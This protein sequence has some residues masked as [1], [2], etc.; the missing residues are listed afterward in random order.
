[1][2]GTRLR[3]ASPGLQGLVRRIFNEGGQGRASLIRCEPDEAG[4]VFSA[5][6]HL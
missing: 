6:V 5:A 3:Q 2:P 1:M 4:Q